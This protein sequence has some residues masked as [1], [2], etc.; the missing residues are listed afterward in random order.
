MR[1]PEK[2]GRVSEVTIGNPVDSNRFSRE[3]S[4]MG[5]GKKVRM[6]PAP[7]RA[8]KAGLP[9]IPGRAI[10]WFM[11]VCARPPGRG[12]RVCSRFAGGTKNR[13]YPRFTNP[14]PGK[15]TWRNAGQIGSG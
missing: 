15:D 1:I 5:P 14:A 13:R 8:G 2:T 6:C 3:E 12:I 4:I 9:Q 10:P 11:L 7:A